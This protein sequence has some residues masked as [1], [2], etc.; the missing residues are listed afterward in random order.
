MDTSKLKNGKYYS[1]KFAEA[2]QYR[3][4]FLGSFLDKEHHAKTDQLEAMYFEHMAGEIYAE[5]YHK[6]KVE[7]I[8]VIDGKAKYTV[9]GNEIM[10]NSGDF[11][12]V[13]VNN[14]IAAEFIEK[15]K[16]FA[17]HSPSIVTDKFIV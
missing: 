15:T 14:V 12:F 6:Q 11:L 8:I 16:L 9:N 3:G 2:G 17:I 1:G 4:W 5:H 13:D 7:L 10:L